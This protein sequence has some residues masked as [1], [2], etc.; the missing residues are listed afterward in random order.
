MN[1]G[2]FLAAVAATLGIFILTAGVASAQYPP[3]GDELTCNVNKIVLKVSDSGDVVAKLTDLSGKPIS[4]EL[5][6]FQFVVTPGDAK[7][8]TTSGVTNALGEVTVKV[9]SGNTAGTIL[10][11][12]YS[13]EDSCQVLLTVVKDPIAQVLPSAPRTGDGGLIQ[14]GG[15]A[16]PL[17]YGGFFASILALGLGYWLLARSDGSVWRGPKR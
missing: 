14:E 10:V 15:N 12:A 7:L 11:R 13:G 3:P 1:K 9:S 5:V 8:G 6:Y 4:G 17:L 16:S 2:M